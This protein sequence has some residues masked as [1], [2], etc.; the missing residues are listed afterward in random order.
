MAKLLHKTHAHVTENLL[1]VV[2]QNRKARFIQFIRHILG[3]EILASF[4]DT[5]TRAFDQFIAEHTKLSICRNPL[6][7]SLLLCCNYI[8][9]MGTGIERIRAA[10][11]RQHCP[12]VEFRVNNSVVP[13]WAVA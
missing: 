11:A 2:Y 5:V 13:P 8:E 12:P 10:V 7:A 3:I 9:K 6:I 4:P 1:R